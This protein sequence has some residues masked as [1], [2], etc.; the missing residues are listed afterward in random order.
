[1]KTYL[2]L[3]VLILIYNTSFAQNQW[4]ETYEDTISLNKASEKLTMDFEKKISKI[5]NSISLNNPKTR[6]NGMGPFFNPANNTLNLPIWDLAPEMFRAFCNTVME[7]EKDG[8]ELFGLFFNGFYVPHEL[9]H[10]LQHAADK[11]FDN[12]YNTEYSA[13]IIAMLYWKS[14]GKTTQLKKC[15]Q[16]ATKALRNIP[17]PV[18]E[19]ENEEIYF[20]NHYQELAKD[21]MKYSYFQFRQYIIA[22]NESEKLNFD[23]YIK[24]YLNSK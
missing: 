13:N 9:G 19:G 5:D 22:Y 10:A 16:Y 20:T 14:K 23:T 24:S 6:F 11:N 12:K 17:N 3:I 15:Y 4:F 2:S 7:N 1:M 8:K 18:P 21:P